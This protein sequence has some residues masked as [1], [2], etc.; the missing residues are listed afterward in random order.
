[1]V[2]LFRS[3][4]AWTA[5]VWDVEK[6]QESFKWEGRPYS[7]TTTRENWF[8]RC[9]VSEFLEYMNP[10]KQESKPIRTNVEFLGWLIES[11]SGKFVIGS[12]AG[13]RLICVATDKEDVVW[14]ASHDSTLRYPTFQW[15]A[16]ESRIAVWTTNALQIRDAKTGKLVCEIPANS[17]TNCLVSARRTTGSSSFVFRVFF[18]LRCS[19]GGLG[20]L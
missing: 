3:E 18:C 15:S 1:M 9:G 12:P 20:W 16:D 13:K 19:S 7:L 11:P 5:S 6:Q 17:D 10:E 14:E 4:S 2:G 8:L